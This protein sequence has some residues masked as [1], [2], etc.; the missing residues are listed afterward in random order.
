MKLNQ[1]FEKKEGLKDRNWAYQDD[2]GIP[3]SNMREYVL[4][5]VLMLRPY[6]NSPVQARVSVQAT[7]VTIATEDQ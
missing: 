1:F 3:I 7:G 4:T 2:A 5:N 6:L